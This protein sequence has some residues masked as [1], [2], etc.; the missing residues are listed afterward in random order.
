M[1]KFSEFLAEQAAQPKTHSGVE[2]KSITI[3]NQADGTQWAT[4]VV[5]AITPD[6]AADT[7]NLNLTDGN[8]TKVVLTPDQVSSIVSGKEVVATH[9]GFE[10]FFGKSPDKGQVTEADHREFGK[11]GRYLV[12]KGETLPEVGQNIDYFDS[13]GDKKYGLVKSI[14]KQFIMTLQ[15][16]KTKEKV[17]LQ[18]VQP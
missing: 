16:N 1:L 12:D 13:N 17:K 18:I 14:N 15:D 2:G 7:F 4:G 11:K 10:F 6:N 9:D 8:T 5:V 3:K